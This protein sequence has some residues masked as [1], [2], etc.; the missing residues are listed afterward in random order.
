MAPTIEHHGGHSLQ[1]LYISSF[2]PDKVKPF[3]EISEEYARL[4][5]ISNRKNM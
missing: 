2:D 3:P 5:A 4:R 1:G